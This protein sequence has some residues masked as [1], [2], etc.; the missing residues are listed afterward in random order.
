MLASLCVAHQDAIDVYPLE[1]L[2]DSHR[3][4]VHAAVRDFRRS[5]EQRF[6]RIAFAIQA[7][8]LLHFSQTRV[9][10]F[11]S[12]RLTVESGQELGA[13]EARWAMVGIPPDASA[14]S[15]VLALS[16]VAFSL[17]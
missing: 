17:R 6:D 14:H 2:F 1:P 15:I 12:G 7:L 13:P 3:F 9:A 11:P 10:V 5:P 8:G 4:E 16:A